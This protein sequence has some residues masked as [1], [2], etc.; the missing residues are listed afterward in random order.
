MHLEAEARAG[1]L[2]VTVRVF[3]KRFASTRRASGLARR[4]AQGQLEAWGVAHDSEA[5][6]TAALIVAELAA[7]AV[8]HAYVS[9]R[10]FELGLELYGDGVLRIEVTD[11]RADRTLPVVASAAPDDAESGRGLLLVQ[12]LADHWGTTPGPSPQKTVWVQLSLS[13]GSSTPTKN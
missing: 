12:T 3:R 1:Q 4:L 2:P 10:G 9:G 13:A 5:S 8:L 6:D 7:N 11:T